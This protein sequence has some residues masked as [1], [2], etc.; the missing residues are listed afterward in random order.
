[1]R[2]YDMRRRVRRIGAGFLLALGSRAAI[3]QDGVVRG[4]VVDTAGAPVSGADV[5]IATIHRLTR[6]DSLGRFEL[7]R[8]ASGT[9]ELSVRRLGFV[10]QSLDV[11]VSSAMSYAY[12][13]VLEIQ[14][15]ELAGVSVSAADA[16]LR[17]GIEDF[18][19]RRA[20]GGGGSYF[21]R[22]EILARHAKRT[23]DVLRTTPGV[24]LVRTRSGQGVRFVGGSSL[25]RECV[26]EV[27]L[28]G[29]LARGLEVDQV[30]VTDIEAMEVYSGPST[31]PMQFSH[32][33]SRDACGVI[34][35]WTR[36]PGS[37]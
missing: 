19:R 27:W 11:V 5:A 28:D 7:P 33:Q 18:Y 22:D 25:R 34:V 8:M 36:I 9:Y 29:Q 37:G 23:S 4:V 10:P 12:R 6:S 26:P 14:A 30:N 1:M 32:A 24:R 20:R 35:I 2:G 13:V 3:A 17:L 15:T 21:T 16:R 31:T